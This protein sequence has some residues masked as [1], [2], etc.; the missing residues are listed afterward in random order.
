MQANRNW[1][2]TLEVWLM[3]KISIGP[4]DEKQAAKFLGLKSSRLLQAWRSRRTGPAWV[5]VGRQIRY[6][7]QDLTAYLNANRVDPR[8]VSE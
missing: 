6:Q 4:L 1:R 5:R 3:E 7:P 8:A 2:A